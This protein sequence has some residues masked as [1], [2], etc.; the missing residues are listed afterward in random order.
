MFSQRFGLRA[1]VLLAGALAVLVPLGRAHAQTIDQQNPFVNPFAGF[2]YTSYWTGQTF[3]PTLTTAAGAGVWIENWNVNT[4]QSGSLTM[5]LWNLRPDLPGS[6]MLASGTAAYTTPNGLRS[7]T[8]VDIFWS[9]VTVTPGTQY[10]LAFQTDGGEF[11]GV[12]STATHPSTY[13]GGEAHTNG[14]VN[15]TDHWD[16]FNASEYDLNFR[17]YSTSVVA[18][19]EPA[20]LIL[21][22]TGLIGVLGLACSRSR[23]GE[24][25][26]R[27][28]D[29]R[30]GA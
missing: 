22:G 2:A 26:P 20:S 4:S 5:E 10:F 21:L 25:S 30:E 14:S 17:E 19:P 15:R 16:F 28:E 23:S 11:L 6:T 18:I 3:R 8:W 9:A 7:G 1:S 12:V 27:S 24:E 29:V 13:A